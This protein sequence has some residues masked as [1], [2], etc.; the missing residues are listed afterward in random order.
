MKQR[1]YKEARLIYLL[2]FRRSL[3]EHVGQATR[4]H[5]FDVS[6]TVPNLC[7]NWFS[8][9]T[10]FEFMSMS[11]TAVLVPGSWPTFYFAIANFATSG[12]I[13]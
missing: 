6:L 4:A 5:P 9:R 2:N 13:V 7:F 11:P 12:Y 8:T 1:L 10:S 3:G